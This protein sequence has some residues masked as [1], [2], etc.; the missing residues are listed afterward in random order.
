MIAP[1]EINKKRKTDD[2]AIWTEALLSEN[3]A[4]GGAFVLNADIHKLIQKVFVLH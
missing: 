1:Y 4:A 3:N 2:S